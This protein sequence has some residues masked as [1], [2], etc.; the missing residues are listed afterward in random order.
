MSKY[1]IEIEDEPLW[2]QSAPYGETLFKAKNFNA[3]VFDKEGLDRLTPLDMELEESYQRGL[4]DGKARNE[5]GCVGCKYDNERID[6]APC[7]YC[8]NAYSNQWTAKEKPDEIKVGD[9][10][11]NKHVGR[12]SSA[13]VTCVDGQKVY[14]LCGDGSCGFADMTDLEKT[15]VPNPKIEQLLEILKGKQRN[16]STCKYDD[17]N[18]VPQCTGC[19]ASKGYNKWEPKEGAE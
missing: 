13:K 2:R 16:C 12:T 6:H 11:F 19:Y 9:W 18:G 4:D 10:V 17:G 15:N 14:M 8:C 7:I 5:N 1:I 3:I